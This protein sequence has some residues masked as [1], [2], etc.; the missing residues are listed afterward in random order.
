MEIKYHF[1]R[2]KVTQGIVQIEKVPTEE[3]PSDFGTKVLPL[4]K[5]K[6]CMDLL[7]IGNG[8]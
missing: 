1:I 5:F 6:Y 7:G 2:D 4:I 3:N 8:G